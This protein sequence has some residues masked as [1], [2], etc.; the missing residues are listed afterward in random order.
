MVGVAEV[1]EV[2]AVLD[3][4][5]DLVGGLLVLSGGQRSAAD[6]IHNNFNQSCKNSRKSILLRLLQVL[7]DRRGLDQQE[8]IHFV[9]LG[10]I[11]GWQQSA[12]RWFHLFEAADFG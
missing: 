1:L 3:V 9:E 2:G 4:A 10:R 6:L 11:A 12:G 7:L 5:E 8:S